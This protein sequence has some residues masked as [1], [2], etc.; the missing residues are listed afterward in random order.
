MILK[1]KLVIYKSHILQA[2]SPIE[3]TYGTCFLN[4]LSNTILTAS[5]N[6]SGV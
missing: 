6:Y 5:D 2:Q 4:E 1:Q 3:D